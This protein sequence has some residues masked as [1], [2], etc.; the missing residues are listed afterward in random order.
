MLFLDCEIDERTFC[1]C[2]VT[3][4]EDVPSTLDLSEYCEPG[5]AVTASS[6]IFSFLTPIMVERGFQVAWKGR[7]LK[8]V[9]GRP[10]AVDETLVS[11][12]TCAR[13]GRNG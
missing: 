9:T 7:Q 2:D 4:G 5:A 3:W 8:L 13:L 6:T 10:A 11:A 1:C 12:S